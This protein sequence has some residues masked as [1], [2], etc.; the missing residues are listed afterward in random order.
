MSRYSRTYASARS[1]VRSGHATR[2]ISA[3][4]SPVIT[5]TR[6]KSSGVPPCAAMTRFAVST[7][8]RTLSVRVPSTATCGRGHARFYRKLGLLRHPTIA[9]LLPHADEPLE[10]VVQRVGVLQ[11]RVHDLEA[12]VAHRILFGEAVE[13]HLADATRPDFGCPA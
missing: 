4:G 2:R 10:L 6:S 1:A 11:I 13:H 8:N 12:Q 9:R 7:T 5:P 3:S